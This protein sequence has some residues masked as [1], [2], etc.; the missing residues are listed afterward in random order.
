MNK[1]F[2]I[3]KDYLEKLNLIFSKYNSI[4]SV[5]LFGSR[6][7]GNY[8]E[9]SDIDL[10]LKGQ[11]INSRTLTQI[12]MDY[13]KLNLPWIIDLIIFEKIE[14]EALKE[15]IERVGQTLYNK[16]FNKDEPL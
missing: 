5:V 14:N 2:G 12:E 3:P 13:D 7:K 6:A 9:G 4:D 1:I 8:R 16:Q 15:H 10:A 11:R